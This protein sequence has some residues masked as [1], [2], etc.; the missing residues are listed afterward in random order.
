LVCPPDDGHPSSTCISRGGLESNSRP[1]SRKSSALTTGPASHCIKLSF[2]VHVYNMS[3][4]KVKGQ[5]H[6]ADA[7]VTGNGTK[8]VEYNVIADVRTRHARSSEWTSL[9]RM[10]QIRRVRLPGLLTENS[11]HAQC[12]MVFIGLFDGWLAW[13]RAG[14]AGDGIML[15]SAIL[16]F[17]RRSRV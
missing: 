16:L 14:E 4:S 8:R 17:I 7:S 12:M 15:P 10:R 13:V 6:Q 5:G 11:V 9:L 3:S 1:S 2:D